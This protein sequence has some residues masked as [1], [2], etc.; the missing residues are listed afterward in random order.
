MR[1]HG[2]GKMPVWQRWFTI[3]SLSICSLSGIAF[4]VGHEFHISK[5]ILGNH[6][7]LAVHGI[8]A[9]FALMAFGA[10]M[11]FHIKAGLKAKK[12]L[13]SGISQLTILA[14]LVITGLLLYY[15]PE[16]SHEASELIHWVLGLIFVGFFVFHI[17]TRPLKQ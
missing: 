2:L 15:G 4:L 13:I 12:N 1:K 10:V 9:A 5:T 7:V 6:S 3:T 16:E 11:P 14:I 17:I 8:A